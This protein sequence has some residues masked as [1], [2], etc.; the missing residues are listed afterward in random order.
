[1][2]A[3]ISYSHK[4]ANLLTQLHE[5]LAALRRQGL[6]D[7]W[8]DREICAGDVIDDHVSAEIEDAELYLLLVSSSFINSN[9]CFDKEFARALVRQKAGKA[10][11]VPVI[12]RECDWQIPELRQFKALP[13]D[14]KAVVSRHWHSMDEG[15]RNVADGLRSLLEKQPG[16]EPAQPRAANQAKAHRKRPDANIHDVHAG[17][18]VVV[19]HA[20]DSSST[21]DV[22]LYWLMVS[23]T[24]ESPTAQEGWTLELFFPVQIPIQCVDGEYMVEQNPVNICGI[25][26]RKLTIRSGDTIYRG[27]TVQIADRLR[28]PLSYKMD[29]DL[30]DAAHG[31]TWQFCWNF[32]AGN[33]P[34]VRQTVPWGA[35][36]EF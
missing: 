32:Y 28:H 13:E 24:N 31:G 21:G 2:R 9:Y 18:N 35:M 7:T 30:Y 27:Q 20:R 34:A 22:H 5:H 25:R 3:F 33:L 4:D 15:F 1:M 19:G 23:F 10:R 17:C 36:H 12:V 8:T 16:S 29:H 6:L 11:I 14:G 26:F